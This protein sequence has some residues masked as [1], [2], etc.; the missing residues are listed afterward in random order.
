LALII[1]GHPRSGTTIL[2]RLCQTHPEIA[3]TGEF[4]SFLR[5]N[6][7]YFTYVRS[8]RLDWYRRGIVSHAGRNAP[9]RARLLSL[10]FLIAFLGRLATRA[11]HR[12]TSE[13][14][15]WALHGVFP[16]ATLVGDK[17]PRYVFSLQSLANESNLKRVIIYRDGR[18]VVNSYLRMVATSWKNLRFVRENQPTA[19]KVAKAWVR[20][21]RDMERFADQLH[22][23]RYEELCQSPRDVLDQLAAYLG[24]SPGG[25][26]E[27]KVHGSSVGRY[28]EGLTAQQIDDIV[29]V[30]GPT[31][32]KLGYPL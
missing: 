29:A 2:N 15:A 8:L 1:G 5:L 27:S 6:V 20:S 7:P 32:E 22:I 21:I 12:I 18:D 17:Y 10:G 4:R 11:S 16:T 31:L 25:F 13:D 19:S 30:S 9:L 28:A 24:V 14:V 23:I 26:K 3:M